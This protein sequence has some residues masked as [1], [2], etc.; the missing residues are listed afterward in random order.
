MLLF[1]FFL[2]VVR[3]D[4]CLV[5]CLVFGASTCVLFVCLFV[6]FRRL[7]FVDC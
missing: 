5:S 6:A 3:C 1:V 4:A 2:F 7:L